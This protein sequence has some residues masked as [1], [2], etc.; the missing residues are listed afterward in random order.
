MAYR[1]DQ[2][3]HLEIGYGAGRVGVEVPEALQLLASRWLGATLVPGEQGPAPSYRLTPD[4]EDRF[5][6]TG[7]DGAIGSSLSLGDA[8]NEVLIAAHGQLANGLDAGAALVQAATLAIDG[9]AI[10]MPGVSR[11][12]KSTLV[13]RLIELGFGYVTDDVS[14]V[15]GDLTLSAPFRPLTVRADTFTEMQ[16]RGTAGEA[17]PLA[18]GSHLVSVAAYDAPAPACGLLLFPRFSAGS[19]LRLSLL[20][21]ARATMRLMQHNHS[22]HDRQSYGLATL[23]RLAAE[24]PAIEIVYG[25]SDQIGG[26]LGDFLDRAVHGA[27]REEITAL[28]P[29]VDAAVVKVAERLQPEAAS[30]LPAPTPRL[31]PVKL[32]IGMATYDDYDGVYFTIQALRLYHPEVLADAEII[33]VDN[34]PEGAAASHLKGLEH[35]IPN[36]RYIPFQG[37][38]G[39]AAPRDRIVAE[40]D[41]RYVLSLDCHVLLVPDAIRRLLA[42]FDARPDCNDLLQ[43]P[44]L[45]DD[46]RSLSPY[47]KPVWGAGMFGQWAFDE[48]ATDPD[49]APFEIAMQGLG[50][51]AFRKEAWPS[52]HPQ[53]RGFGGEEFY[54]HEKFRHRGDRTLC[55]P[56]LRWMHRFGR[57]G[58]VPYRNIWE[59]RIRNYLL[60]HHEFGLS[61]A[62]MEAHFGQLLGAELS[63]R[64]FREAREE[65]GIG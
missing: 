36:Y 28:L 60:G 53:F 12:G 34:H 59:D 47:W 5:E 31:G 13:S 30:P 7:P 15:S 50:L 56:F 11:G 27:S 37:A 46:A 8:F 65:L 25:H 33:V 40:A 55:L 1:N 23:S 32:T 2:M 18:N 52:F 19:E 26:P 24:I 57:P 45:Y 14:V 39:T 41:G 3:V 20:S 54:I 48:R 42:Y 17:L 49:G 63:A 58:G 44:L 21:P 29:G 43:G 51:Y 6:L 10:L 64:L 9:R 4:G 61:T 22:G 38:S 62:D 35:A 16:L